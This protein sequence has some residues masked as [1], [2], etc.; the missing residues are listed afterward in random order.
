MKKRHFEERSQFMTLENHFLNTFFSGLYLSASDF[1]TIGNAN[2]LELRMNS[3]EMLIK[4]LLNESN[5][6]GTLKDVIASLNALIDER[7][8]TCHRLSLEYPNARVPL[9]K[10][11]QKAN[12]TKALLAREARG[13]PY[14][15]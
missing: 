13:N 3:R 15:H 14:E 7:V 11:A 4:D 1:I 12:G 10:L 9:A 6:I 2:G 5:K 8:S